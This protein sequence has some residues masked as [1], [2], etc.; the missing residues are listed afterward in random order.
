MLESPFSVHTLAGATSASTWRNP[1][2]VRVTEAPSMV[3]VTLDAYELASPRAPQMPII[4][5]VETGIF[6][7]IGPG[8]ATFGAR[9]ELTRRVGSTK[10]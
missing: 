3:D 7:A 1:I 10:F 5:P 8:T 6:T 4:S 2:R 9:G